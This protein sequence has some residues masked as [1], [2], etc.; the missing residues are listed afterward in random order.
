M[1]AQKHKHVMVEFLY[2]MENMHGPMHTCHCQTCFFCLHHVRDLVKILTPFSPLLC[3]CVPQGIFRLSSEHVLR[4]MRKGRETLLTLLEAFV[5]DPLV[6]WT[7]GNEGGYTGAFYGGEMAMAGPGSEAGKTKREMELDITLSMFSIRCAEMSFAWTMNKWEL[8]KQF[9]QRHEKMAGVI[10][11][12]FSGEAT[13]W[14]FRLRPFFHVADD[15][16]SY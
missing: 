2:H 6:D 11:F 10:F 3:V 14:V 5:Y 15:I 16:L 8:E 13:K 1:S 4:T 12:N 7:T 9:C